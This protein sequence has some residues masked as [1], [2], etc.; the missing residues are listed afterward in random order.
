VQLPVL[1]TVVLG[2]LPGGAVW[3]ARLEAIGL[4]V[5][6]SG[7]D[8][9]T[10]GTVHEAGDAVPHRPLVAV[11]GAGEGDPA[12]LVAAGARLLVGAENDG[13]VRLEV[14]GPGVMVLVDG[15]RPDVEDANDVARALL[16]PAYE[17]AAELWAAAANL[18]GVSAEVA[19]AKLVAL[20]AGTRLA[21][22]W[23]AK[24][25]FPTR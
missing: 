9:D 22:L 21:R 10:P 23:L 13:A 4:D 7:A 11:A 14:G 24:E 12:G 5:V 8:P 18:G 16:E 3:A 2:G 15:A 20:V 19:E 1:P 17:R 25:Q 6:A